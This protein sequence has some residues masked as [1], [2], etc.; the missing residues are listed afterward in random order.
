[1]KTK[2][3]IVSGFLGAGKS[4]L[5]KKLVKEAYSGEKL[6]IVQNEYGTVEIT[7]KDFA[8]RYVDFEGI[9]SGCICCNGSANFI[10]SIQAIIEWTSPE[11]IL[12][13]PSGV[14]R[15]S[16]IVGMLKEA[17]SHLAEVSGTAAVIDAKKF[18]LY[19]RN[20]TGFYDNQ[21]A[22]S[23][24]VVISRSDEVGEDKL[25]DILDG[26][27]KINPAASIF[28]GSWDELSAQEILESMS[29][30]VKQ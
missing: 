11:R 1:M 24:C 5:I 3:D 23:N 12:L 10:Q 25:A 8:D 6:A 29:G 21:I 15:T 18:G 28:Y 16:D 9:N 4:S 20:Y 30:E 17:C 13:E 19:L 22:N 27:K 2:I 7:E 14:A 26:V